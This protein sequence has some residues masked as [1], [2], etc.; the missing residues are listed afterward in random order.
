MIIKKK[1]VLV[2]Q[3]VNVPM[4]AAALDRL[5]DKLDADGDGEVDYALVNY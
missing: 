3:S 5:V 1:N 2:I 4:S